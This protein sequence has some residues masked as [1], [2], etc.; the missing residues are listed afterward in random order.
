MCEVQPAV[1]LACIANLLVN[2]PDDSRKS[3]YPCSAFLLL[4]KMA[5][6]AQVPILGR[7]SP[8]CGPSLR[9]GGEKFLNHTYI[10]QMTEGQSFANFVRTQRHQAQKSGVCFSSYTSQPYP[11]RKPEW[12]SRL[13]CENHFPS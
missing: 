3:S 8:S 2:S 1:Q 5:S 13:L 11:S 10:T 9:I 4:Q 6:L 12:N 7:W